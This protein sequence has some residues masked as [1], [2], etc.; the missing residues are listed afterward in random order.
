MQYCEQLEKSFMG[1][2]EMYST[3]VTMESIV[4]S[5]RAGMLCAVWRHA[6]RDVDYYC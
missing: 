2:K 6:E 5:G 1:A 3:A 4:V